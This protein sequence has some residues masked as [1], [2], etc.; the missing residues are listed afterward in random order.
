MLLPVTQLSMVKP[1]NSK[2]LGTFLK[3]LHLNLQ[4]FDMHIHFLHI[5]AFVCIPKRVKHYFST[6]QNRQLANVSAN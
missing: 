1:A 5:F 2:A 6:L 4:K 3:E